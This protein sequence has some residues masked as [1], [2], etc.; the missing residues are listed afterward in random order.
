MYSALRGEDRRGIGSVDGD[1]L[2]V[3]TL[4]LLAGFLIQTPV[5]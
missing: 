2:L 5:K 1:I 3:C 4:N